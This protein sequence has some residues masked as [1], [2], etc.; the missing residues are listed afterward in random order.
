VLTLHR[1]EDG[2]FTATTPSETLRARTVVVATGPFQVPHTPAL[3]AAFDRRVLQ[4]HSADYRNASQLPEGARVLVVGAANSGA[5]IASELAGRCSVSLAVG[6]TPVQLPQRLAGRDLFFWLVKIGFF[7]L[8][9]SSRIARRLRRRGDL[10]IGSSRRRLRRGGV[11]LRSRLISASGS[12]ASFADGGTGDFDAVIWATGYKPDYSWLQIPGV[13][14]DGQVR[15]D[16]GR[17]EVPGLSFLGLPWQTSRGSALL[18]FVGA[19]AAAVA[20]RLMPDPAHVSV[21]AT[22]SAALPAAAR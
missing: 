5:Q 8:P 10:V 7:T 14:V 15:H 4:L 2:S 19:D 3:A 1:D 21:P 16:G 9:A 22:A 6:S 12:T 20:A 17:T 11:T 13:V 18:G